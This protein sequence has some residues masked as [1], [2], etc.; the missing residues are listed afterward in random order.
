MASLGFNPLVDPAQVQN[1][2]QQRKFAELLRQQAMQ[3]DQGQMVS[4]H[5]VAPSITQGLARLLKGYSAGQM[6]K[7]ANDMQKNAWLAQLAQSKAMFGVDQPSDN[8]QG[9]VSPASA[10]SPTNASAIDTATSQGIP[11]DQAAQGVMGNNAKLVEALRGTQQAN[12][13]LIPDGMSGNQA[14]MMSTLYPDAYEA[15]LKQ[16]LSNRAPTDVMK[17]MGSDDPRMQAWRE[18]ET[19]IP[20]TR[21]GEGAYND[22]RLGVQGLPTAAPQGYIN[23]RD[24]QTGQWSTKPVE[25]GLQAN[26]TSTGTVSQAKAAGTNSVTPT[27]YFDPVSNTMKQDLG[28]NLFPQLNGVINGN[29]YMPNNPAQPTQAPQ[30]TQPNGFPKVT[31]QQQSQRDQA[32]L[33]ILNSELEGEKAKLAQ[34]PNDTTAATNIDLISKEIAGTQGVKIAQPQRTGGVQVEPA[35][36][37]KEKAGAN[38]NANVDLGKQAY[39]SA[40]SEATN[41]PLFKQSLN[42]MWKLANDPNAKFGPGTQGMARL[43]ALASNIPGIDWNSA[44]TAQDIMTKMANFM[45]MS[46]LGGGNSTGTNAQLETIL[47][48]LPNGEMTNAAM[49]AV[50]P[51]LVSQTDIKQARANVAQN[52]KAQNNGD[53]SNLSDGLNSF[54]KLADPGTVSAG[55][56]MS[57]LKGADLAKYAHSLSPNVLAK[58]RQLDQLGAFH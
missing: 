32:R 6:D 8:T 44:Q 18:K 47:H 51:L 37:Q 14:M 53:L 56:T 38:A 41:V 24:P 34:N 22:P 33:Q 20:P 26:A 3:D 58:V 21:L 25:G 31:P 11:Q 27:N 16:S 9:D 40:L 48:Q 54:N 19:Y 13:P 28:G 39:G 55:F 46:Q 42:E 4:G 1:I 2:D 50:I 36:G 29:N 23:V 43:K 30:Q 7:S 49:K 35:L 57:K 17:N 12:N 10:F 5:Y 15:N 45:A 52:I